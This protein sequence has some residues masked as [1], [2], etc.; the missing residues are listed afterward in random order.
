MIGFYSSDP[1]RSENLL[2]E[3]GFIARVDFIAEQG[4]IY[5]F[6]EYTVY[7]LRRFSNY[8]W[9]DG[10]ISRITVVL[11]V[12]KVTEYFIWHDHAMSDVLINI[13]SPSTLGR[14]ENLFRILS[15]Y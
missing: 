11:R 13:S 10:K 8:L 6:T 3:Q 2:L 1:P 14:N 9:N 15:G 4:F 5:G 12:R 7:I